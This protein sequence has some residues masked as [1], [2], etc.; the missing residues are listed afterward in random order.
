ME[1][2]N[3]FFCSF[4]LLLEREQSNKLKRHC[5]KLSTISCHVSQ[6]HCPLSFFFFSLVYPKAVLDRLSL[7]LVSVEGLFWGKKGIWAMISSR[8]RKLDINQD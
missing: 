6:G 1:N 4:A 2:L 8:T 3:F 5:S 7:R